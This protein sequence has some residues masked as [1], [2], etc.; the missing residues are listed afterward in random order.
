MS[1]NLMI[2][3]FNEIMNDVKTNGVAS[4]Y[5]KV[6]GESNA[7]HIDFNSYF[8]NYNYPLTCSSYFWHKTFFYVNSD[9]C[10]GHI[11]ILYKPLDKVI[12]IVNSGNEDEIITLHSFENSDCFSIDAFIAMINT[13]INAMME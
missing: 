4:K 7:L 3:K 6:V 12:D 8:K 5:L 13:M 11:V 9:E 2:E 10:G 1:K